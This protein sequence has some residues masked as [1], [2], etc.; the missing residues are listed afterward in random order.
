M[1]RIRVLAL[2]L[3]FAFAA[4]GGAYAAWSDSTNQETVETEIVNIARNAESSDNLVL[5]VRLCVCRDMA[6]GY[7]NSIKPGT[8]G[9]PMLRLKD[10]I[11]RKT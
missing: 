6:F 10:T 5:K 7:G 4:L 3:V 2:V 11:M 9:D 1:K 8:D